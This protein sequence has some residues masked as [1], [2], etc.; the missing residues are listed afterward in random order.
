MFISYMDENQD[1]SEFL[2]FCSIYRISVILST[3]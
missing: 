3:V 2:S 1:S